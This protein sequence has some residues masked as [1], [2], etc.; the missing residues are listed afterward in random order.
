MNIRLRIAAVIVTIKEPIEGLI[1]TLLALA[2]FPISTVNK[3]F[4][5]TWKIENKIICPE[6]IEELVRD[7]DLNTVHKNMYKYI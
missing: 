4:T 3:V 2:A 5:I 6:F 1:G 7:I